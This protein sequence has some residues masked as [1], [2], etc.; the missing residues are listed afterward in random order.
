MAQH[1][2]A[3]P[4]PVFGNVDG[5]TN[6]NLLDVLRQAYGDQVSSIPSIQIAYGDERFLESADPDFGYWTQPWKV[7]RILNR[8]VDIGGSS[9]ET[10]NELTV[11]NAHFQDISIAVGNNIV[12]N[13]ALEVQIDNGSAPSI[14]S[15]VIGTVPEEFK[16]PAVFDGAPTPDGV[17]AIAR[18]VADVAYAYGGYYVNDAHNIAHVIAAGAGATLDPMTASMNP[19]ENQEGGFWRIAYRGS[20]PDPV[21]DWETLVQPGDIVR[22]GSETNYGHTFTVTEGLNADGNHPGMIEVVDNGGNDSLFDGTLRERWVNYDIYTN[23][24]DTTIYRLASD[25]KYLIIGSDDS[26]T[27]IGTVFND[28]IRAG[29]GDDTL[30]GSDGNDRLDGGSGNDTVDFSG[31]YRDIFVDLNSNYS[32]VIDFQGLQHVANLVSIENVIGGSGNNTLNG[33]TG[34]NSLTGGGANDILDGG[35]GNDTLTGFTGNNTFKFDDGWG[36]D[37]ITDFI[38]TKLFE[39]SEDPSRLGEGTGHDIID[40]TKDPSRLFDGTGHDIIDLTNVT[41]LYSMSQLKIVDTQLGASIEFGTNSILLDGVKADSLTA[42]DFS[43]TSLPPGQT[44]DATAFWDGTLTGTPGA[45]DTASFVSSNAGIYVDLATGLAETDDV[46]KTEHLASIENVTGS[47]TAMN[48]LMGDENNNILIGGNNFN[49][50]DGRD[51]NNTLIG[52]SGIDLAD[53]F[54]TTGPVTIDLPA[55]KVYHGNYVDAVTSIEQFRGTT[56]GDTFTGDAAND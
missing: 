53:Y 16:S 3:L 47:L 32:A 34:P 23:P 29:N 7:T 46:S 19:A 22:V 42:S 43:F 21:T 54:G 10:L 15:L 13:V 9:P 30:R 24:A 17:V 5:S 45:G 8:G 50:F 37:V 20:D 52:G 27:I 51:G 2:D 25:Q 38:H 39:G 4:V 11:N 35:A 56:S 49:W 12:S 55:G 6:V 26:D 41:G 33:D 40:V 1:L 28:D 18:Q 48:T 36:H 14:E 44:L 31:P